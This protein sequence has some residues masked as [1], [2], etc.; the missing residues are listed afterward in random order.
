MIF[1]AATR[2][3]FRGCPIVAFDYWTMYPPYHVINAF[4]KPW[5][6]GQ[7][8]VFQTETKP[9]MVNAEVYSLAV[10]WLWF[11]S[12]VLPKIPQAGTWSCHQEW[13]CLNARLGVFFPAKKCLFSQS[14]NWSW[15]YCTHGPVKS[16]PFRGYLSYHLPSYHLD[17][18]IT[19]QWLWGS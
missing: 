9:S 6:S 2:S 15:S 11:R 13:P 16:C 7:A 18:A 8:V 1:P 4:T 12:W 3:I 5:P 14:T 19:I 10:N 17:K